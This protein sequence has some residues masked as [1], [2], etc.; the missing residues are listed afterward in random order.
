MNTDPHDVLLEELKRSPV[1]DVFGVVDP[2][3]PGG[4]GYRDTKLPCV[5]S[6]SFAYWKIDRGSVQDRKLTIR[7]PVTEEDLHA[8]MEKL[9]PYDVVHIRAR[10]LEKNSYGSPQAFLEEVVA[11]DFFEGELQR[12]ALELQEPVTFTDKSFGTFTL[13]R[14]VDWYEAVVP[15]GNQNVRLMLSVAE[16]DDINECLVHARSI[17]TLQRVW[18]ERVSNFGTDE[19]FDSRDYKW[20]DAAGKE[21]SRQEFKEKIELDSITVYADGSFEFWYNSDEL[22]RGHS[23]LVS[24]NISDGPTHAGLEG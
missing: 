12:R 16:S 2:I 17:W 7:K 22:F 6:L 11:T 19:F 15:W 4:A 9:R 18:D 23:I 21:L 13:D 10:V 1:V 24:G 3:G 20:L 8:Y 14:S 5:L